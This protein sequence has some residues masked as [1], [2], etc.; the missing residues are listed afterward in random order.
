MIGHGLDDCGSIPV[1]L[2]C[3]SSLS[4]PDWPSTPAAY[5]ELYSQGGIGEQCGLS[6]K[7][8]SHLDQ[9]PRLNCVG[10]HVNSLIR[11]RG[12]VIKTQRPHFHRDSLHI[13]NRYQCMKQMLRIHLK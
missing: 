6:V 8:A 10:I 9:V 11:Y 13:Y 2:G 1:R 12:I 4:R 5:P 7:L 3:L